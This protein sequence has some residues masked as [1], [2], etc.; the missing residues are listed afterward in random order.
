MSP[1]FRLPHA[2]FSQARRAHRLI[3]SFHIRKKNL[4]LFLQLLHHREGDIQRV[5][6]Q[7]RRGEGKPLGQ[8]DVGHAVAL[9]ELDPDQLFGV[10]CVFDV[11]TCRSRV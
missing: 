1:L 6:D 8:A 9:V 10:G 5:G 7:V 2:Q 3:A 4:L 11:V